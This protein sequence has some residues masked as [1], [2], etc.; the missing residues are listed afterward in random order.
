MTT[1][2]FD[3]KKHVSGVEIASRSWSTRFWQDSTWY[4]REKQCNTAVVTEKVVIVKSK[5][6]F[7]R[8]V[9]IS[10]KTCE[11]VKSWNASSSVF[12]FVPKNRDYIFFSK[13]VK[14][15]LLPRQG[16]AHL[17]K[18]A[19]Y[20][21]ADSSRGCQVCWEDANLSRRQ[22]LSNYE[23]KILYSAH[24]TSASKFVN[25]S[26]GIDARMSTPL[27]ISRLSSETRFVGY[28][29]PT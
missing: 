8:S 24:E 26:H 25:L 16:I 15:V 7:S 23:T 22:V 9:G 1:S 27:G 28:R 5:N 10:L 17:S 4:Q 12:K 18:T 6:Q 2:I 14:P 13:K 20:L 3:W 29:C 19:N 21:S 11:Y